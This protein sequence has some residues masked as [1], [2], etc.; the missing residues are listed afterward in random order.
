MTEPGG[1]LASEV[2]PHRS[3]L[4][5]TKVLPETV[6]SV[7]CTELPAQTLAKCLLLAT[8][9][10][11]RSLGLFCMLV[12]TPQCVSLNGRPQKSCLLS[13][14]ASRS[15]LK[16]RAPY[17]AYRGYGGGGWSFLKPSKP[18]KSRGK[19]SFQA[20]TNTEEPRE[21]KS[22]GLEGSAGEIML[23]MGCRGQRRAVT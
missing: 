12:P 16:D 7:V 6:T 10:P 11:K 8:G 4:G 5:A 14:R 17:P 22:W 23:E 18:R 1:L 2:H 20:E 9:F 15:L 21:I 19:S 3:L 13:L